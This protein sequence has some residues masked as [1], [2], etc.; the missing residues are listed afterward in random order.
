MSAHWARTV[1]R[2]GRTMELQ[3]GIFEYSVVHNKG[4]DHGITGRSSIIAMLQDERTAYVNVFV[5][6]KFFKQYRR[7]KWAVKFVTFIPSGAVDFV[8][9]T[10]ERVNHA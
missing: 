9:Y 3:S 4:F 7:L 1:E 10:K 8:F 2:V 5:N 6:G